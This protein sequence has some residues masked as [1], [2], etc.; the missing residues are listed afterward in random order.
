MSDERRE[1]LLDHP[2]FVGFTSRGVSA[3]HADWPIY[4]VDHG[5]ANALRGLASYPLGTR[6]RLIDDIDRCALLV[7]EDFLIPNTE[8]SDSRNWHVAVWHED[9]P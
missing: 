4:P 5:V 9:L 7:A 3:I 1:T 2:G 8:V 6:F